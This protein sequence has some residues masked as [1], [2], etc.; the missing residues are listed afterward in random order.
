MAQEKKAQKE[1]TQ[2]SREESALEY[3]MKRHGLN[4][5]HLDLCPNLTNPEL[6]PFIWLIEV[7]KPTGENTEAGASGCGAT[8]AHAIGAVAKELG[9]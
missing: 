7:W 5:I 4:R 8:L 1:Q 6:G 2:K 3:L 9:E